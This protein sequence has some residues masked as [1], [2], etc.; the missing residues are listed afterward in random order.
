MGNSV[1]TTYRILNED[2]TLT[3]DDMTLDQISKKLDSKFRVSKN[4][5]IKEIIDYLENEA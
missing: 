1:W 4:D 3:L 5:S 2:Q